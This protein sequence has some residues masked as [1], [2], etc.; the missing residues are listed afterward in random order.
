MSSNYL[1]INNPNAFFVS[2]GV[3][4]E[5]VQNVEGI[6]DVESPGVDAGGNTNIVFV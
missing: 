4:G 5:F 2:V 1:E 6:G 3:D